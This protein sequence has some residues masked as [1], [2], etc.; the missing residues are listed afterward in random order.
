MDNFIPSLNKLVV[1]SDKALRSTGAT[2]TNP[3]AGRLYDFSKA[4]LIRPGGYVVWTVRT[5]LYDRPA[6]FG[7]AYA[8]SRESHRRDAPAFA[9]QKPGKRR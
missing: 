1:V 9:Q 7:P 3:S 4:Q 6:R 2:F 8:L 5:R